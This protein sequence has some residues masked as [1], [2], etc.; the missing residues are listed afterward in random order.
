MPL[1]WDTLATALS[2]SDEVQAFAAGDGRDCGGSEVDRW[3]ALR[4]TSTALVCTLARGNL[5]CRTRPDDVEYLG[6]HG[7]PGLEPVQEFGGATSLIAAW[8]TTPGLRARAD[9]RDPRRSPEF[10]ASFITDR[11]DGEANPAARLALRTAT[12]WHV[13]RESVGYF[14]E[15]H[16]NESFDAALAVSGRG[17]GLVSSQ[18]EGCSRLGETGWTLRVWREDG[19]SLTLAGEVDLGRLT[20]AAG[21]DGAPGWHHGARLAVR[22]LPS[23]RLRLRVVQDRGG[24]EAKAV[25]ERAGKWAIGAE[26]LVRVG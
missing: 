21:E 11:G 6:C 2:R 5:D 9:R 4:T 24:S 25:R 3:I 10:A 18:F 7:W 19:A 22:P 8:E 23:G 15:I 12:G 26:G 13:S 17:W 14:E 20:F 16:E 1:D